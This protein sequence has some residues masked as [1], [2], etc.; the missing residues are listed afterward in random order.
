MF[1]RRIAL[2]AAAI[3]GS[4]PAFLLAVAMTL[5]WFISGP[6]FHFSDSW[7]LIINTITSVATFLMVFL[8]QNTQNRDMS[9]LQLKLDELIRAVRQA[10]TELVQ[11]E[12]LTDEELE[13]LREEF[14]VTRE[15]AA[16]Q[17]EEI[18]ASQKRRKDKQD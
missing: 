4:G 15:K 5:A 2:R 10:R 13:K 6:Y 9:V 3:A 11:M 17:I 12:D 7:Q 16:A 18:E 1:F 14:R 8:I